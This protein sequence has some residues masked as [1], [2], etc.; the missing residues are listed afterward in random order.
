MC[1]QSSI[2]QDY[3]WN[4]EERGDAHL[5]VTRFC[6]LRSRFFPEIEEISRKSRYLDHVLVCPY[7]NLWFAFC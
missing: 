1:G 4:G 5:L 7:V 2:Q 6:Y 3:Q